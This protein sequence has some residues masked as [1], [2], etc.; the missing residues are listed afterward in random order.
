MVKYT[1]ILTDDKRYVDNNL[2]VKYQNTPNIDSLYWD[3]NEQNVWLIY[4]V[5]REI[6]KISAGQGIC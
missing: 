1:A 2:K 4:N 6:E 5:I 3:L